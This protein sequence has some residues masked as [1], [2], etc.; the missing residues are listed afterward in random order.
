MDLSPFNNCVGSN[1]RRNRETRRSQGRDYQREQIDSAAGAGRPGAYGPDMSSLD[2]RLALEANAEAPELVPVGE[3]PRYQ[4]GFERGLVVLALGAPFWLQPAAGGFRLWVEPTIEL[5]ARRQLAAFEG[6]HARRRPVVPVEPAPPMSLAARVLPLL[7]ALVVLAGY[8]AQQRWPAWTES[9]VLDAGRL[10]RHG[11]IWRLATALFLHADGG[12][13]IANGI[14][15]LFVLTAVFST[16]GAWR[17][18]ALLT[19]ASLLGNLATAALH[20]GGAYRSLG[21]STALFAGLGLLIG[22]AVAGDATLRRR[23]LLIP[24]A[25][26]LVVLGWFGGGPPPV[27]VTAHLTG[28]LAGAAIGVVEGVLRWWRRDRH[29]GEA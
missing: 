2:P 27:D 26:G 8:W 9:G 17:G 13:L 15:G 14:S 11:E 20:I 29:N 7:W 23:S 22:R 18:A 5:E 12:H 4:D 1:V 24:V 3:Y 6:E 21:A 10:F 25:T 16:F 28:F 19:G